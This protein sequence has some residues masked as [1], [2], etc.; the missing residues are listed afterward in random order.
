[1]PLFALTT[2][3]AAV[4]LLAESSTAA[5]WP[6]PSGIRFPNKTSSGVGDVGVCVDAECETDDELYDGL[7]QRQ[8]KLRTTRVKHTLRNKGRELANL[9]INVVSAA[10]FDC[11]VALTAASAFFVCDHR[12]TQGTMSLK[13]CEP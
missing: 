10:S 6:V 9:L 1:M 4:S 12:P 5:A 7:R 8:I 3:S 2:E 11:V 13:L